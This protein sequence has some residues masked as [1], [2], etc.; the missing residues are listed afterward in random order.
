MR[1]LIVLFLLYPVFAHG[2]DLTITCAPPTLWTPVCRT[3]TD[4]DAPKPITTPITFNLYRPD[5]AAALATG[6]SSCVFLR[7]N[8]TPGATL[9]HYVTAVVLGIESDPSA[10]VTSMIPGTP[11]IDP[12]APLVTAG[13]FSYEPTGTVAAPTMSAIG[14]IDAGLSCGPTTRVVGTV[15]FCQITRAQTDLIGWPKDKTLS[16][17]LWAKTQ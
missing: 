2:A 5:Q 14:L 16:G 1:T 17:G 7:T 13:P 15:K 3:A 11:P 8:L 6:Y 4:C 12:P 9:Q 10:V